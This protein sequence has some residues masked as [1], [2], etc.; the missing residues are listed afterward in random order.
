MRSDHREEL[1]AELTRVADR[2]QAF[3]P[4]LVVALG[5]IIEEETPESDREHVESVRERLSFG[6]PLRMLAGNH[7][8]M[9]L[10]LETL[11]SLFGNPLSVGSNV[12]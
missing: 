7:D 9:H 1:T 3:D 5:D 10:S 8:V 4:D 12:V 11:R 2:L 6:P